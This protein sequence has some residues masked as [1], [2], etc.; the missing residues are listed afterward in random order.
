MALS[1]TPRRELDIIGKEGTLSR[2][3]EI[4]LQIRSLSK[5]ELQE[6]RAGLDE[7]EAQSWDEQIAA[8]SMAGKLDSLIERALKDEREGKTTPL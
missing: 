8:D 3:Q 7:I 6:L 4:E 5:S 2:V 1:S